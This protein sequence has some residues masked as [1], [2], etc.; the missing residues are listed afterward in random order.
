MT[1]LLAAI[2]VTLMVLA[3]PLAA[4]DDRPPPLP[5]PES[6]ANAGGSTLADILRRQEAL[7]ESGSAIP[8]QVEGVEVLN[9]LG[10]D[11]SSP[12]GPT[13]PAIWR[14]VRDGTT[15]VSVSTGGDVAKVLV[16][17]GGMRWLQ[18]RAGP[19]RTWG[20]GLLI[21]VAALL[22]VFFLLRG[23]IRIDG[24]K[25]GVTVTRFRSFER[26]AHWLLAGSFILLA[27]T[28]L[29]ALFG[30]VVLVPLLGH[31]ANAAI[32]IAS[33]W[34]HNN[35]AW[36]FMVALVVVFVLWVWHNVPNR[37]DLD[38]VRRGGGFFGGAHPAAKKFNFGQKLIF[39]S[40][41]LLGASV[42]ASGLSLLFP[43]E[44]TLFAGTFDA[45][46]ATGLPGLFGGPLDSALAPQEEMQLAQLW[47]SIVAFVFMAIVLA[48]IY[49]GSL[50]ME[51][52][53][54]AMGSGQVDVAWA[55][56]HHALWLEEVRAKER[57]APSRASGR[58]RGTTATPAE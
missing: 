49:L 44:L 56:Q 54:D 46:N 45:L 43:F 29:A 9:P 25:S 17:D 47:H 41:I 21:G 39:W 48:H 22:A 23:R 53:Y 7:R 1:R 11:L 13:D 14:A 12:G 28:G 27:L 30:R 4:Q 2:V 37:T 8:A 36:P 6:Q 32:L 24:G 55:E 3:A 16:Q 35:V 57:A 31:E 20:G 40:V 50:G 38:W 51:G 58:S 42:S 52:A 26:A 33:K 34:V 19:L 5:L 10:E 15:D 18:W